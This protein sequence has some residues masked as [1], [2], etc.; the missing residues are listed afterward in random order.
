MLKQPQKRCI[1]DCCLSIRQFENYYFIYSFNFIIY[2]G[3]L[4][5]VVIMSSNQLF[6]EMWTKAD[7]GYGGV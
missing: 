5:H 6:V 7:Y 1:N 4:I 2:G 3:Y